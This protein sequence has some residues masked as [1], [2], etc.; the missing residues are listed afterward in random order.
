M[1]TVYCPVI[2]GRIDGTLCLEISLV[3]DKEATQAI[4][5]D[6]VIW[7]EDQRNKCISCKYHA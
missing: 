4:L 2:D 7:D 1:K 3:A 5:P 6:N